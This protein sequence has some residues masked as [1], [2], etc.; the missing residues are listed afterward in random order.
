[1]ISRRSALAAIGGLLTTP[2]AFF[3]R[4][5]KADALH[6]R[7]PAKAD[8]AKKFLDTPINASYANVR[9]YLFYEDREAALAQLTKPPLE[10]LDG[11]NINAGRW[12]DCHGNIWE[13]SLY[14]YFHTSKLTLRLV[15]VAGAD[16][17]FPDAPFASIW[18]RHWTYAPLFD[19]AHAPG[20]PFA[21]KYCI[22]V[23]DTLGPTAVHQG[24]ARRFSRTWG[25]TPIWT[26][27]NH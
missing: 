18:P 5:K 19:L 20:E 1:M 8:V 4:A 26:P 3:C 12:I 21:Y 13:E 25:E 23:V 9:L 17:T 24:Q 14:V 6:R 27:E 11:R 7:R 15:E 10:Y 22:D 16:P 2:L